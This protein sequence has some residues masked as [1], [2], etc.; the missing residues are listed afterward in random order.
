MKRFAPCALALVALGMTTLTGLASAQA[1]TAPQLKVDW[2]KGSPIEAGPAT[3]RLSLVGDVQSTSAS[4]AT[5]DIRLAGANLFFQYPAGTISE[6]A[7][8]VPSGTAEPIYMNSGDPTFFG[9]SDST[10]Y[11]LTGTTE[12]VVD[13]YWPRTI[14]AAPAPATAMEWGL[15]TPNPP[16]DPATFL[17]DTPTAGTTRVRV[18]LLY[19]TNP[20]GLDKNVT[21]TAGQEVSFLDISL[22]IETPATDFDDIQAAFNPTIPNPIAMLG[23]RP[24]GSEFFQIANPSLATQYP[25]SQFNLVPNADGEPGETIAVDPATGT[26]SFR[27]ANPAAATGSFTIS[28]VNEVTDPA[29]RFSVGTLPGAAIAPGAQSSLIDIAFNATG[30]AAG[31]YTATYL[32]NT[33]A[34]VYPTQ[35]LTVTASVPEMYVAPAT[36]ALAEGGTGTFQVSLSGPPPAPVTVTTAFSTGDADLSVSGGGSLNFNSTNWSTSQTVTLASAIDVD[37]TDDSATFSVTAAGGANEVESV[38]ANATD[39][40][41]VFELSSTS[42]SVAENGSNT[43]QVRLTRNYGGSVTVDTTR[44]AGS[45]VLSV[46]GG[47]S[48]TFTTSDFATFQPVTISSAQDIDTSNDTATFTLSASGAV[49]GTTTVNAEQLDNVSVED[50]FLLQ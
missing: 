2:V 9:P 22:N 48:L 24:D 43:F 14:A 41:P 38:T 19:N 31:S 26:A 8:T 32:V 49:T 25:T 13:P 46:T 23:T 20:G 37:A 7:Y 50:W 27:V 21:P 16:G 1:T 45:T 44:T 5:A 29:A 42:V 39:S 30:A 11:L 34:G 35:L 18:S 40:L 17:A 12:P 15:I 47:G 4:L 6:V 28:S 36:V 10:S 3:M 33:T